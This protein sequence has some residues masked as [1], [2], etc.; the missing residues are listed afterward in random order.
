LKYRRDIG[1]AE[2]LVPQLTEFALGLDWP[3]GVLVPVPLGA[4]R[5]R[6]RGY[7]QAGLISW[8]L[9][10]ALDIRHAP[11]ALTRTRETASQVGLSREE[12]HQNVRGAF[13]A[14]PRWVSGRSILLLDDVATTGATLSSCA[15][16]LFAA[17]A[18]DVFALTVSRADH[19]RRRGN[20]TV[21]DNS[22]HQSESFEE[23]T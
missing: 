2:A 21:A 1:L 3:V 9:S 10:L 13:V 5:L 12:R 8:P 17:G 4:G 22:P 23:T 11:S 16:A 6:D 18:Q 14:S 15:E 20:P 19:G 7:N